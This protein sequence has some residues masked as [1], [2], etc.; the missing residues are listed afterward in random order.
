MAHLVLFVRFTDGCGE[1]VAQVRDDEQARRELDRQ[2]W[3]WMAKPRVESASVERV[4][5]RTAGFDRS[6]GS[7]R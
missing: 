5:G 2:A 6:R 1:T 3:A 7:Y 4:Q